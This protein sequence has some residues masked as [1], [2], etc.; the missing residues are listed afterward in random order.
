MSSGGVKGPIPNTPITT[1][2][3]VT[4][5]EVEKE[6]KIPGGPSVKKEGGATP[7]KDGSGHKATSDTSIEDRSTQQLPKANEDATVEE[8]A[9]YLEQLSY[10]INDNQGDEYLANPA[11]LPDELEWV[12]D[13]EAREAES[14]AKTAFKPFESL[15][16]G[17]S[18]LKRALFKFVNKFRANKE[19]VPEITNA[20]AELVKAKVNGGATLQEAT[21]EVAQILEKSPKELMA[22]MDQLGLKTVVSQLR[23]SLR[24]ATRKN[25]AKMKSR[26]L[27]PEVLSQMKAVEGMSKGEA[28][29]MVNCALVASKLANAGTSGDATTI[30]GR[31]YLFGRI[32][33]SKYENMEWILSQRPE[34]AIEM[35]ANHPRLQGMNLGA[36]LRSHARHEQDAVMG[37]R[38]IKEGPVTEDNVR[39]GTIREKVAD[40][41]ED[42][43]ED[44]A[45]PMFE[46]AEADSESWLI[47]LREEAAHR[48]EQTGML[49]VVTDKLLTEGF[50]NLNKVLDPDVRRDYKLKTQDHRK[51]FGPVVEAAAAKARR[52][53]EKNQIES[54]RTK[55]RE[56]LINEDK[57][58]RAKYDDTN[59]SKL[60]EEQ[61][62]VIAKAYEKLYK[63]ING[64]M[65]VRTSKDGAGLL[66]RADATDNAAKLTNA[67]MVACGYAVFRTDNSAEAIIDTFHGVREQDFKGKSENDIANAITQKE[68]DMAAAAVSYVKLLKTEGPE[69][70]AQMLRGNPVV[71]Q[72]LK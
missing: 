72:A 35:L 32:P 13:K 56:T 18:R 62:N 40:S 31:G 1:S 47:D 37:P 70:L 16:Q 6:G 36:K 34:V 42:I 66:N 69:G 12:T 25:L 10:G 21:A 9:N 19:V 38:V 17:A 68:A 51:K 64:L 30:K 58:L 54:E 59:G 28:E 33:K 46:K 23:T 8:A 11:E 4:T 61:L 26:L 43:F 55:A 24:V 41:V 39:P 29:L 7:V 65:V 45:L 60:P 27:Q 48:Y 49:G 67:V 57:E 2:E 5:E 50:K 71:A 3:P 53:I 52:I 22:H 44:G 15:K 14:E 63:E 20:M